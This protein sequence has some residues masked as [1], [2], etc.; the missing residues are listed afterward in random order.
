MSRFNILIKVCLVFFLFTATSSVFA[1]VQITSV[2]AIS[3]KT[4]ETTMEFK[5]SKHDSTATGSKGAFIAVPIVITDQNLGY[6][7]ILA[8]AYLHPN[9]KSTQKNTPPNITSIA[10]GATTT[11]TWVVGIIHSRSMNNDKIRYFGG[12]AVTSVNMDF[13]ELGGW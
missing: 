4:Q 12:V 5:K 10:G 1:Q 7:A 8:P 11:K 3:G 2:D 9:K 13:F 6:G